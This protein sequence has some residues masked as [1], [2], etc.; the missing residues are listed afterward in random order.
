M[1]ISIPKTKVLHVRRQEQI[2]ETTASEARAMCKFTCAHLNCGFKF[3]NRRGMQVHA[4]KCEH[5][6]DLKIRKIL[7]CKGDVCARKYLI[8]WEGYP[9]ETDSWE[10]RGNL[11]P[12]DI[13]MFEL[14]NNRYVSDWQHRCDICDLPCRSQRGV[15]VHKSKVHKKEKDQ[16]FKDRLTDCVVKVKKWTKL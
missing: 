6:N 3:H 4:S 12:F 9:A 10:P 15:Q 14:E 1:E 16:E 7:D 8:R 13:R 2:T 11:H 5:R